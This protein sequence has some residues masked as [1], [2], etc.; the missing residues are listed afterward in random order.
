VG[1]PSSTT[2]FQEFKYKNIGTTDIVAFVN[3]AWA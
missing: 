1:K 2:F 3:R